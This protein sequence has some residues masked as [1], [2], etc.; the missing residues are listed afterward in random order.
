M[1]TYL[2]SEINFLGSPGFG[3]GDFYDLG[4]KSISTFSSVKWD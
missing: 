1:L 3:T 2:G 4:L